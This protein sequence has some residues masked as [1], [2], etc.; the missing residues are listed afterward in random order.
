MMPPSPSRAGEAIM[1]T[2]IINIESPCPGRR[3]IDREIQS[4]GTGCPRNRVA[5][6]R[7]GQQTMTEEAQP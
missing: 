3:V 6:D 1:D 2:P 7:L 4:I 5:D